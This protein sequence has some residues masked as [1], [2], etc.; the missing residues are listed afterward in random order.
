MV[1]TLQLASRKVSTLAHTKESVSD[2]LLVLSKR[3]Q[4]EIT[5]VFLL[6]LD[7]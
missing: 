3:L 6:I 7:Y 4:N 2:S 5:F 1:N